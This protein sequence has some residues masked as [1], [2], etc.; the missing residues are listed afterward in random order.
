MLSLTEKKMQE[1]L[2]KLNNYYIE[3]FHFSPTAYLDSAR[4]SVMH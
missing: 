1:I 2:I 3:Y 4:T